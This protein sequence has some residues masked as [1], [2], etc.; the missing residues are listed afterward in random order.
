[1]R[2]PLEWQQFK[3]AAWRRP[4]LAVG[5]ALAMAALWQAFLVSLLLLGGEALFGVTLRQLVLLVARVLGYHGGSDSILAP[6]VNGLTSSGGLLGDQSGSVALETT[7]DTQLLGEAAIVHHNWR[8]CLLGVA[9]AVPPAGYTVVACFL[10]LGGQLGKLRLDVLLP[11]M[12]LVM[13]WNFGCLALLVLAIRHWNSR[14][15]R[16]I[17]RKQD[18]LCQDRSSFGLHYVLV[19]AC[20]VETQAECELIALTL[21]L[22]TWC[23]CLALAGGALGAFELLEARRTLFAFWAPKRGNAGLDD[24]EAAALEVQPL[25]QQRYDG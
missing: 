14:S 16:E 5:V 4:R 22:Y 18:A 3:E 17:E 8:L 24:S 19:A 25:L 21:Y 9:A 7:A 10:E 6:V 23:A 2:G 1:M 11:Q 12:T 13:A 15:C 20:A